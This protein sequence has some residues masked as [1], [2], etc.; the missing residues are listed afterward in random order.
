MKSRP[1]AIACT[2]RADLQSNDRPLMPTAKSAAAGPGNAWSGCDDHDLLAAVSQGNKPAFTEFV[3]RHM[4][5]MLGFAGRYLGISEAEDAVQEAFTRVW[6]KAGQWE[7]RGVSPRSWLMRIVYNLCMDNLRRR[8]EEDDQA[9]AG[10]ADPAAGPDQLHEQQLAQAQLIQALSEL[11]ERQRSALTLT[12]YHALSN[13]ETAEVLGVSID[14][15]E[16]LLSRGRRRL[17]QILQAQQGE[18]L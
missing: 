2:A 18:P 12:V 5:G 6:L 11:P 16:S 1:T 8:H 14:A 4:P 10:L 17:K 9:L 7:D 15:L 3:R 13:R